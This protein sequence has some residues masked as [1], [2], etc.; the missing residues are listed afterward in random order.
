LRHTA[1]YRLAR[2]PG[3][4]ITDVQWILGHQS[5]STT[6]LYVT[7]T[8]EDVIES[9]LAHH[10]RAGQREARP[11]PPSARYRPESLDVLFG[12]DRP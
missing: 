5:L 3:V 6:Q 1:A 11:E 7:P 8:A 10:R 2:D 9:V 12:R 4:P